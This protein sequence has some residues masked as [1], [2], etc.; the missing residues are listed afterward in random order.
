MLNHERL[1]VLWERDARLLADLIKHL[2][3]SFC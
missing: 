1:N 2:R 3:A